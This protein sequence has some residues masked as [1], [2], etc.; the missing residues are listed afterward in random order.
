M[1]ATLSQ[2][3]RRGRLTTSLGSDAIVLLRM[4]GSEELSG[5][6]EW[7]VEALSEQPEVDLDALLGTHA[8]VGIA[9]QAET[10]QFDGI[11]CEAAHVGNTENGNRYDFVLRPW[12]HLASLR[13]NQRIF[14]EKTVV[15]IIEEVLQPYADHVGAPHLEVKL[16][17][18]YPILEYTVQYGE[19]DAD[20]CRRL[21][22]RFGITWSYRHQEGAHI[23]RLTDH[24][25][26]HDL[27]VGA[28]GAR[29]YRGVE[30]WHVG[31]EEH[32]REWHGGTRVTTGAVR[33]TEYNFK[34]P[35]AAQ[36]VDRPSPTIEDKV[37]M[38]SFDWPGD[39]LER[40]Q[41]SGVVARRLEAERGQ[42]PRHSA[43][44]DV[45]GLGA[46]TLVDLTGDPIPGVTGERYLCLKA[47]HRFKS[48]AYGSG[49]AGD[50]ERGYD[51]EFSLLP[52]DAPFRPERRTRRPIIQGPQT[53]VVV[54]D[55]EIDC[56]E[57]GRILV[58]FH[59]DLKGAYS[60]RCRVPR[61]GPP[62]AG[63]AW[64]S[65]ESAWRS[66]SSTSKATPT[67]PSSPAASTMALTWRRTTCRRTRLRASSGQ[68]RTKA[69]VSTN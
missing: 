59:W 36:E 60:M 34:T 33:L 29:P 30:R 32:F 54:G 53:A 47:R 39:Y 28:G 4:D 21:M 55:G 57:F 9:T 15:Q 50:D 14:H 42:A 17:D 58:K 66:S 48:Q 18:D 16:S 37:R 10:R 56:D 7:R 26:A 62:R 63:A 65:R 23:L 1:V 11:I 8:T 22:E 41:G 6:F 35:N 67:S 49:D 51:G 45:A 12:L 68:T 38:E 3:Q 61:A 27:V 25:D 2:T 24:A 19:S 40:G 64:S 43:R 31:E 20:F 52:A 44:G 13:R 5:D 69:K 46:G